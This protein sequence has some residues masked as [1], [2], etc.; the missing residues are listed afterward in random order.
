MPLITWDENMAVHIEEIDNQHK[1]FVKIL[2]TLF[3]AMKVAK[4]SE[5]LEDVINKV[6]DY[7]KHHFAV[8]ERYFDQFGYSDSDLHKKEHQNFFEQIDE[9]KRALDEGHH[10]RYKNDTP[11][12]VDVWK[13]LKHWLL[14]HIMDFDKKYAPLFRENGVK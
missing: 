2:N 14:N 7:A 10:L 5:V 8:E 13:L 6:I 4:G 11:L 3:D 9:F 1:E 12:S